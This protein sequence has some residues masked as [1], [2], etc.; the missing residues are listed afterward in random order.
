LGFKANIRAVKASSLLQS[1]LQAF[2]EVARFF[3]RSF[4]MARYF[5]GIVLLAIVVWTTSGCGPILQSRKNAT[6]YVTQPNTIGYY[7]PKGLIKISLKKSEASS[8]YTF[9]CTSEIVP[10]PQHLYTLEYHPSIFS[11]DS[12]REPLDPADTASPKMMKISVNEKGL[13]TSISTHAEDQT[14]KIITNLV[15]ALTLTPEEEKKPA[16]RVK[17]PKTFALSEVVEV[18][19]DPDEPEELKRINK[20]LEPLKV[21]VEVK[22]LAAGSPLADY[23]GSP[24]QRGIYYRPCLPYVV[25][26]SHSRVEPLI[27]YYVVNSDGSVALHFSAPDKARR[28]EETI[29]KDFLPKI[30]DSKPGITGLEEIATAAGLVKATGEQGTG[31]TFVIEVDGSVT[32]SLGDPGKLSSIASIEKIFQPRPEDWVSL[33]KDNTSDLINL[34]RLAKLDPDSSDQGFLISKVFQLPNKSPVLSV[35]LTRSPFITKEYDLQFIDG[36]LSSYSL[37]KPSEVL[38]GLD[39]PINVAKALVALPANLV[40]FKVNMTTKAIQL[41]KA[42]ADLD[43]AQRAFQDAVAKAEKPG[44]EIPRG[45]VPAEQQKTPS[46]KGPGKGIFIQRKTGSTPEDSGLTSDAKVKMALIQYLQAIENLRRLS[47]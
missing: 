22:R 31:N 13:L 7:L 27:G 8:D 42:Q 18:S 29:K 34:A 6:S 1:S 26:I 2:I 15:N 47:R 39:I 28:A 45:K 40:T 30:W 36:I 19:F 33:S 3:G 38:A 17:A 16:G 12:G 14:V 43:A 10:D 21:T 32:L 5:S 23:S 37:K 41:Q 24:A 35:D 11:S 9:D 46:S 20:S 44:P 25:I 4:V